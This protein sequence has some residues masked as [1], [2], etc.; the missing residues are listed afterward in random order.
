MLINKAANHEFINSLNKSADRDN[1]HQNQLSNLTTHSS[2]QLN[3]FLRAIS[4]LSLKYILDLSSHM[5]DE[6]GEAE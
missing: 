3:Y 2:D 4:L 6:R 5:K 1:K